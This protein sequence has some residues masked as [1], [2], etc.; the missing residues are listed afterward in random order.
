MGKVIKFPEKKY[1]TED[2]RSELKRHMVRAGWFPGS[3][4][5]SD[6]MLNFICCGFQ[7]CYDL[8]ME[9]GREKH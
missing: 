1:I 3:E 6:D 8:G 9:N 7:M 2:Y 4:A 5:V